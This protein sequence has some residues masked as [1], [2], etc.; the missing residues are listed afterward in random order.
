M[1]HPPAVI[2]LEGGGGQG[3]LLAARLGFSP[4]VPS[5]AQVVLSL[6]N[7]KAPRTVQ[8]EG[9]ASLPSSAVVA[10]ES[11]TCDLRQPNYCLLRPYQIDFMFHGFL[12]SET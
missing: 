8:Y 6:P 10:M 12:R 9:A 7:N 3:K 1:P 2:A 11:K 4:V 5:L